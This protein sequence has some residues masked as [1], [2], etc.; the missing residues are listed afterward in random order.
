MKSLAHF[1]VDVENLD[2]SLTDPKLG[3]LIDAGWTVCA[4]E[5]M[6][7]RDDRQG[8]LLLLAPP[9]APTATLEVLP[10]W[11]RSDAAWMVA[12]AMSGLALLL[13]GLLL[14]LAR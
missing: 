3:A 1:T 6:L 14:S 9:Q 8:L 2:R 7:I 12:G 10:F 5:R 13:L 11:R 4:A